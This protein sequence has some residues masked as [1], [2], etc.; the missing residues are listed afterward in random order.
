M[1]YLLFRNDNN[2]GKYLGLRTGDF[3]LKDNEVYKKNM[4]AT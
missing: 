1:R 2:N 3:S 4:I